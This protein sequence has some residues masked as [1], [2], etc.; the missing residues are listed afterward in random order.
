MGRFGLCQVMALSDFANFANGWLRHIALFTSI[1]TETW[2][3]HAY[4][5]LGGNVLIPLSNSRLMGRMRQKP[6]SNAVEMLK[7]TRYERVMYIMI[8]F[9]FVRHVMP[10]REMP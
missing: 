5:G 2:G 9:S 1:G 8:S 7:S 4:A 3:G 6:K 10:F